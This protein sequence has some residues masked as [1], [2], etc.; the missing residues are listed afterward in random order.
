MVC[1]SVILNTDIAYAYTNK[2]N[3]QQTT[4]LRGCPTINNKSKETHN[5]EVSYLFS[6]KETEENVVVVAALSNEGA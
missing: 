1:G 6:A 2:A 3:D 5:Y 4:D